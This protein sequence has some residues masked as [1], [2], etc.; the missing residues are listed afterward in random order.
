MYEYRLAPSLFVSFQ[1]YPY[2]PDGLVTALPTSWGALPFV[3]SAPQQLVLPCPG[4]E[5]FWIGLVSSPP[6]QRHRLGI[7]VW[8]A[9][10]AWLDALTGA[11]SDNAWR[12]DIEDLPM[13]PRYGIAGIF[14]GGGRWWPF[15]RSARATAAPASRHI[16]LRCRA[17]DANQ[18]VPGSSD[19]RR[20]HARPGANEPPQ[21]QPTVGSEAS[22]F[23]PAKARSG[24]VDSNDAWFL[25]VDLVEPERFQALGGEELRPLN[26]ADRY[27]GGRLP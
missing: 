2:P 8:T 1:R 15:A 17:V 23:L 4:G 12:A 11:S 10:G 22:G 5:A 7:L 14:R 19:W 18:P 9:H 13:A 21:S 27:G 25:R 26:T 6:G 20:Q 24:D 16:S 3:V